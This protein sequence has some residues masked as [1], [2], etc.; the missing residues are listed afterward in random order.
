MFVSFRVS[1]HACFPHD[2]T[3]V[4]SLLA[5]QDGG[6]TESFDSYLHEVGQHEGR[7]GVLKLLSWDAK[8]IYAWLSDADTN[9]C[10][11][12]WLGSC[13]E[14]TTSIERGTGVGVVFGLTL[15]AYRD[16]DDIPESRSRSSVGFPCTSYSCGRINHFASLF[17]FL[18]LF[19]THSARHS[20]ADTRSSS[21]ERGHS[22]TV[23]VDKLML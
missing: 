6:N 7:S 1:S 12:G 23:I 11:C 10:F 17:S 4:G 19:H 9:V 22:D 13:V 16:K 21:Q 15:S 3:H 20:T 14:V 5:W 8:G 18:F 2:Y